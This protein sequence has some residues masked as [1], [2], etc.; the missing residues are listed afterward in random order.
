MNKL[1]GFYELKDS[2]LPTVPWQEYTGQA[3]LP[4]GFLWTIRT[5]V[6]KGRDIGLTRYVGI[7]TK[8]ANKKLIELY[9]KY[10]EIGMVVYYPF[11]LQ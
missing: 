2:S 7:G 6:Y 3:I 4:E 8:E 1:M 10:K 11:L 9:R 5:A